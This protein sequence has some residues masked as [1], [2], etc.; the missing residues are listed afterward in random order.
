MDMQLLA[1]LL[2]DVHTLEQDGAFIERV[3]HVSEAPSFVFLL[4]IWLLMDWP[5]RVIS[6]RPCLQILYGLSQ[7]ISSNCN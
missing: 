3:S 1:P 4:T 2:R 7:T 6:S 5:C